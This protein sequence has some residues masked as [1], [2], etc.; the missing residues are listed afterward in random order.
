M[1]TKTMEEIKK[2]VEEVNN[3]NKQEAQQPLDVGDFEIK[4][5][6]GSA[7]EVVRIPEGIYQAVF[8][9]AKITGVKTYKDEPVPRE[10]GFL[11]F[12]VTL[13]G[14]ETSKISYYITDFEASEGNRLGNVLKCLKADIEWGKPF[15]LSEL[16][17]TKCRVM[18]ED[19][20]KEYNGEKQVKSSIT[21]V[22]PLIEAELRENQN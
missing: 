19:Y 22:K 2:K 10:V 6:E 14:K 16:Y 18:I 11:E 21:K 1:E 20:E 7:F 8:V 3:E 12:D 9:N 5:R 13:Q 17:G 4:T 15:I